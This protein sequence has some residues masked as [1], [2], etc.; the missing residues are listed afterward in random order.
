MKKLTTYNLQ[1]TT[2]RG[3]TLVETLVAIS[4]LMISLAGPLV[5]VGN[6]IKASAYARDQITA[7]YL[8]QDAVEALRFLRD[9]NRIQIVNGNSD[10]WYTFTE[11]LTSCQTSEGTPE[12][13]ESWCTIDTI[14]IYEN[15][16]NIDFIKPKDDPLYD[17]D[18]LSVHSSGY[19]RQGNVGGTLTPFKRYF[20]YRSIGTN[21]VEIIVKIDWTSRNTPRNFIVKENLFYWY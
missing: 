20:T 6:G 14:G 7:F 5:I 13:S 18:F 10:N 16:D 12:G 1:L 9:N 19:Y 4:I 2:T 3:F 15:S 17:N 8:A 21:E 11:V